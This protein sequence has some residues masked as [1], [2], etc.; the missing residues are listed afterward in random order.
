MVEEETAKI[1]PWP[2][3]AA[4][5]TE[6]ESKYDVHKLEAF[7]ALFHRP[8]SP[9][10]ATALVSRAL[11]KISSLLHF[12]SIPFVYT[13]TARACRERASHRLE[14]PRVDPLD[15]KRRLV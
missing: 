9:S 1:L 10:Q 13:S 4:Y 11:I 12:A 8:S 5:G 15:Q 7:V 2:L 6:S 3:A 14:G